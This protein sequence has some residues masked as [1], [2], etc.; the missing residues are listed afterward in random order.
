MKG[1]KT[2]GDCGGGEEV[3]SGEETGVIL[4]PG[5]IAVM[6]HSQASLKEGP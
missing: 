4:A 5:K 3:G 6:K 2:T 1:K